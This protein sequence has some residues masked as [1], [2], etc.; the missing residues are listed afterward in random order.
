MFDPIRLAEDTVA[1]Y[2]A[3]GKMP[4]APNE[5]PVEWR[6]PGA[7]FVSIKKNG[8]LRGCVGTFM[9]TKVS[10]VEEIMANAVSSAINDHRFLPVTSE[11]LASLEF[12]IDVLDSPKKVETVDELN[13]KVFGVIVRAGSRLGLLLPDI[14]GVETVEE[15]VN[16]AKQKAGIATVE[17]AELFSFK[18]NRFKRA[19]VGK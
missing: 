5:V 14:E 12:S 8:S 11:E 2:L 6:K 17:P 9:P 18:V 16:I 3:T 7:A 13:P 15:Q 10:L 1:A 4:E 19:A